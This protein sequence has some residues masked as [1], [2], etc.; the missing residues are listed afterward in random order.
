MLFSFSDFPSLVR[1]RPFT[2]FRSLDK[3]P[4]PD[5][6][7]SHG[8]SAPAHGIPLACSAVSLLRS[9]PGTDDFDTFVLR[10]F[11]SLY[12]ARVFVFVP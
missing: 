5:Q 4:N 7:I 1:A 9:S 10:L 8:V 2:S 12:K 3:G 11:I 6:R